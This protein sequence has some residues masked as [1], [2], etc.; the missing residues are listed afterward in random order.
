MS[1][2]LRQ[3]RYSPGIWRQVTTGGHVSCVLHANN[4][5]QVKDMK[6]MAV[7]QTPRDRRLGRRDPALRHGALRQIPEN[8]VHHVFI[9]KMLRICW[10][11]QIL[12]NNLAIKSPSQRQQTVFE[13]GEWA[14]DNGASMT[15]P[16]DA[17]HPLPV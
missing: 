4:R 2:G 16:C 12:L 11:I 7:I 17:V 1:L 5:K 9:L 3:E 14:L 13:G 8:A 15:R 6:V 10:T